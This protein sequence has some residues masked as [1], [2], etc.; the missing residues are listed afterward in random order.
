MVLEIV[1][2]RLEMIGTFGIP[3][4]ILRDTGTERFKIHKPSS[5]QRKLKKWHPLSHQNVPSP[6]C[7]KSL[8]ADDYLVGAKYII[9]KGYMM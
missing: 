2:L 5:F 4:R 1:F 9:K 6:V 7:Q 3:N 8:L